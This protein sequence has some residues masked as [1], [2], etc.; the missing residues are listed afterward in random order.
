MFQHYA[1]ERE[2]SGHNSCQFNHRTTDV[3]RVSLQRP[4][5]SSAVHYGG[6]GEIACVIRHGGRMSVGVGV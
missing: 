6:T 5:S 2:P 3:R 1:L 4:L